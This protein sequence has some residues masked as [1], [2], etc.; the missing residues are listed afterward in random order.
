MFLDQAA[1]FALDSPIGYGHWTL[2]GLDFN[3]QRL[4]EIAQGDRPGGIR[5][6]HR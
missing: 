2:V 4:A 3:R 5:E 1:H 6:A